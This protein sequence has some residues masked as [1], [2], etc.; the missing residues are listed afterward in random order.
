MWLMLLIVLGPSSYFLDSP[1]EV[2]KVFAMPKV[3]MTEAAC[4]NATIDRDDAINIV[5]DCIEIKREQR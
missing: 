4:L 5:Y 2:E 1:T 3:Y